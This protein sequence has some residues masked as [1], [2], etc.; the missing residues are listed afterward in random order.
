LLFFSCTSDIELP[1]PPLEDMSGLSSSYNFSSSSLPDGVSSSS[2]PIQGDCPAGMSLTCSWQPSEVFPGDNSKIHFTYNAP[3][4]TCTVEAKRGEENFSVDT[5]VLIG[6]EAFTITGKISCGSNCSVG[7]VICDPLV[8]K[9]APEPV[10]EGN[11]D[12]SSWPYLPGNGENKYL[13]KSPTLADCEVSGITVTND[14]AGCGDVSYELSGDPSDAGVVKGYAVATCRGVKHYLDSS[15]AV[16]VP[17][18][19]WGGSCVWN[20]GKDD[21]GNYVTTTGNGALPSGVT[22]SNSYGR[23]GSITYGGDGWPSDGITGLTQKNYTV[24]PNVTCT[25]AITPASACPPLKVVTGLPCEGKTN[26]E[27]Y[28]P[29]IAWSD[30]KWGTPVSKGTTAGCYFVN[31]TSLPDDKLIIE[32][33]ASQ[34]WKINGVSYNNSDN[35]PFSTLNSNRKDGGFYIYLPATITYLHNTGTTLAAM[36]KPFCADGIHRLFCTGPIEWREGTEI[37]QPTPTCRDGSLAN[38]VTFQGAPNWTNPLVGIYT[39]TA[40]AECANEPLTADCGNLNVVSS[41]SMNNI[42]IDTTGNKSLYPGTY[43]WVTWGTNKRNGL[44]CTGSG[45]CSDMI[46]NGIPRSNC[47]YTEGKRYI[48]VGDP[49]FN[50]NALI[51]VITQKECT[52]NW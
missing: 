44:M 6:N 19:A 37:A 4:L 1:P 39:V 26:I 41:A 40:S 38:S 23:C 28:C 50:S 20:V 33:E 32:T 25:P 8:I 9:E 11:I 47:D 16:V 30:V 12:C 22:V 29:G 35:V 24:T 45:G 17:D 13:S 5:D 18:P 21:D 42:T 10:I 15:E 51:T 14:D 2:L 52:L 43:Y 48:P 46:V 27:D 7:P 36:E 31:F 34:K 49:I 3:G